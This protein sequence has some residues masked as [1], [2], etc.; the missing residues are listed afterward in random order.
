MNEREAQHVWTS[1]GNAHGHMTVLEN[2]GGA[3][4]PDLLFIRNGMIMF[5]EMKKLYTA[6]Y[7]YCGRYQWA[8]AIKIKSQIRTHQHH[9]VVAD[10]KTNPPTFRIYT[11]PQLNTL[12]PMSNGAKLCFTLSGLEPVFVV[13]NRDEFIDY[14]RFLDSQHFQSEN[15]S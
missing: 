2:I 15:K 5:M 3:S 1:Y 14:L 7:I 4:V 8:Y 13:R 11:V 12:S 10:P 6:K 9:Y